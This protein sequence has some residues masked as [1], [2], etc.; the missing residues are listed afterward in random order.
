M[1]TVNCRLLV[2][3]L[4]ILV[5]NAVALSSSITTERWMVENAQPLVVVDNDSPMSPPQQ[6]LIR[7]GVCRL[8]QVITPE[9]C[10]VLRNRI[11]E[12]TQQQQQSP[13]NE[14]RR[15]IPQTRC[16]FSEPVAVP[17]N[18]RTDVLLPVEDA[19]VGRL[20]QTLIQRLG[21]IL[22]DAADALLLVPNDDKKKN[23]T[24]LQLVEAGALISE[25][26]A[27]DQTLHADFRRDIPNRKDK[28]LPPRLVT[29]LYLQDAPSCEYGPTIFLPGTNTV[30][31]HQSFLEQTTQNLDQTSVISSRSACLNKG[32]VVMYDA[33]VLHFGSANQV[34][35]NVRVVF[36]F[37]LS[38]Y[39]PEAANNDTTS[40]SSSLMTIEPILVQN[41]KE[42]T[43]K[44]VHPTLIGMNE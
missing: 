31:G 26:G 16:R 7:E 27:T 1:T 3:L 17:L 39:E 19:V 2:L 34:P 24:P 8:N 28:T 25:Y 35:N 5:K 42:G 29:F 33:S 15:Y 30:Q 37:G 36:Y 14:D 4:L 18:Q 38:R 40:S 32:D 6:T 21:P 41:N 12:F 20:L 11:L 9:D 10:Q 13:R 44:F 23:D 22:Q 43:S